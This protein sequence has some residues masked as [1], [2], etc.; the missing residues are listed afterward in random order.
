MQSVPKPTQIVSVP[1]L[2]VSDHTIVGHYS[3]KQAIVLG[4]LQVTKKYHLPFVF[5]VRRA[6]KNKHGAG[7]TSLFKT[8]FVFALL[9]ENFYILSET[10]C[11]GF[12]W[13]IVHHFTKR[14]NEYV[15]PRFG[16]WHGDMVRKCSELRSWQNDAFHKDVGCETRT[17]KWTCYFLERVLLLWFLFGIPLQYILAGLVGI[18]SSRNK[19]R[20]TVGFFF[21]GAFWRYTNQW[22]NYCLTE[23]K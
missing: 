16:K 17:G 7:S 21:S 19:R 22:H 5:W 13:D 8:L 6:E 10:L 20:C 23:Q 11:V 15:V 18:W 14:C 12:C 2:K 4:I 3:H 1:A 9:Q